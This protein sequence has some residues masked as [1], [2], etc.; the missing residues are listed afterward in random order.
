M[1]AKKPTKKAAKASPKKASAKPAKKRATKT[2]A[3][4]K[5]AAKA[6]A[7]RKSAPASPVLRPLPVYEF[8]AGDLTGYVRLADPDRGFEF[9]RAT[10][11]TSLPVVCKE[12]LSLRHYLGR[13]SGGIL[14]PREAAE[15]AAKA[16]KAGITFE[17]R[18]LA[19]WPVEATARYE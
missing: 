13:G 15:C 12:V 5:A 18:K 6:A 14:I 10:Q 4:T 11:G 19:K 3:A 1:R 16:D 17:Y 2:S 9:S 7:S 8:V